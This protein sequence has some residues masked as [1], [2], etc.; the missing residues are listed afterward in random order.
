MM[1]VVGYVYIR[2]TSIIKYVIPLNQKKKK[3]FHFQ[4]REICPFYLTKN[5]CQIKAL[6]NQYDYE[7]FN[8]T[9]QFSLI[10]KHFN[11]K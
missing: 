2:K 9:F 5:T 4:F 7:I 1:H 6:F 8:Q 11:K 10:R 3:K